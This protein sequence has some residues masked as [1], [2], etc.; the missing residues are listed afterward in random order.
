MFSSK[1][2]L[3]VVLLAILDLAKADD[4]FIVVQYLI[5]LVVLVV[6]IAIMGIA[7]YKCVKRNEQYYNDG[8]YTTCEYYQDTIWCINKRFE[9][10]T[11]NLFNNSA[12][13]TTYELI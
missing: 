5:K 9:V 10:Q 8:D 13:E 2:C 7:I 1:Q 11:L 3:L 6:I 12:V 4:G